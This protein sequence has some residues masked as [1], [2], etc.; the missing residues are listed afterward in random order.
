MM[1]RLLLGLVLLI[2]GYC[3]KA[4]QVN[5]TAVNTPYNQDFNSLAS[6]GTSSATPVGWYFAETGTNANSS[7]STGTGSGNTGDTYSFGPAGTPERAFGGLQSGSLVPT[8]G[9]AFTNNTGAVATALQITY[10]GEQ[11]RLGA[12]SRTLPDRLDFQYS[13]T[14][15]S[16][17]SGSWIDVNELDFNA[18]VVAG[19]VGLLDGNAAPNRTTITYTISGLS[20]PAGATFWI[21][22]NSVDVTNADDGLAVDD[23]SITPIG[24]S[25]KPTLSIND[26]TVTEG[27]TG[28]TT[29]AFTV[30][31]SQ[32]APAGGVTFDIATADGTATAGSDYVAKT[33][34]GQT[35]AAG[36]T[37]YT[38][39]V[40]I[41]GDAVYEENE[42]FLVKLS[43]PVNAVIAD[44]E[45]TGT[46]TNDDV[47]TVVVSK[48]HEIQ[49]SGAS[50]PVVNQ[51]NQSR[52]IEGIVVGDFQA[53]G[54][55]GGFYVEEEDADQDNNSLTSEAI[56]V[57]SLTAVNVGDRVRVKG[58]VSEQ[59][60]LTRL[61]SANVIVVNSGNTLP[62]A[63]AID[64]PVTAI[65]DLERYESMLVV[66]PE[67][68]TVTGTDDLD[69]F[70]EILLSADGRLITPTNFVDPTDIPSSGTENDQ[71]NV[72]AVTA[73]QNLNTLRSI[74]LDDWAN[75]RL[76]TTAT[77]P[78][79]GAAPQ[80]LRTGS[81]L[82]GLT[83]ILDYGFN[84][85]RVRPSFDPYNSASY[86]PFFTYAP[87][88]AVPSVGEA[89]VRTASFNVLNYFNGNGTGGGFPAPG[90]PLKH[91]LNLAKR[92][93]KLLRP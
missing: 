27:N 38:F 64:L 56:F 81:T 53:T 32:P 44:G 88:P 49:G 51:S 47:E 84:K 72:A 74:T 8:T 60:M 82:T 26:A 45:G 91:S 20:I 36:A 54:Q 46:I 25:S 87:R 85:Y 77:I 10:T 62:L 40:T 24:E 11:W 90:R 35:I 52:T 13:L 57:E 3:S 12:A 89:N 41:N 30:S 19:T 92:E 9:A 75:G 23:F 29:A 33:L 22:W 68:L 79:S 2:G 6:S 69:G 67:T 61:V 59:F 65:T 83:G 16:L 78:S 7:Y 1:R 73:Q 71:N 14:A 50:S 80:T 17:T 18:P 42:T 37:S 34:T 70:G 55:L 39:E 31:L 48:I 4:Q 21:R 5:L 76:A 28:T 43:N 58:T 93:P 86:A 66:F 63:A 15:T